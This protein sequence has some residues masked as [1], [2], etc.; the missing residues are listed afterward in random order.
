VRN[1][2]AEELDLVDDVPVDVLPFRVAACRGIDDG[3]PDASLPRVNVGL[4][5]EKF[6]APPRPVRMG[7]EEGRVGWGSMILYEDGMLGVGGSGFVGGVL[8]MV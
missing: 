5:R 6:P 3:G 2:D 4:C 1:P 8:L 7:R